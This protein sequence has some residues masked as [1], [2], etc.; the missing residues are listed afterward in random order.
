VSM[1]VVNDHGLRTLVLSKASFMRAFCPLLSAFAV[2]C[3]VI[4]TKAA[5]QLDE[6]PF[7]P[8]NLLCGLCHCD[9]QSLG[10]WRGC[11]SAEGSTQYQS[12]QA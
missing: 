8:S 9:L 10:Q 3:L 6:P 11:T 5:L 7:A 1:M 2:R 4:A 12:Q